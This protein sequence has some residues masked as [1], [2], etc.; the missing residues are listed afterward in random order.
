MLRIKRTLGSQAF[1]FTPAFRDLPVQ[2]S[3]TRLSAILPLILFFPFK[4]YV[5]AQIRY[6]RPIRV[7]CLVPFRERSR[8]VWHGGK[9]EVG[10]PPVENFS[11]SGPRQF[12]WRML[13]EKVQCRPK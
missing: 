3:H 11:R 2:Q 13:P 9:G 12:G 6:I 10:N 1:T 5:S 8:I 7:L 4:Q